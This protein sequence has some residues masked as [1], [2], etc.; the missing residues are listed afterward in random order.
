MRV[1][2]LN[3]LP[4]QLHEGFQLKAVSDHVNILM[5]TRSA[6][7]PVGE[8]EHILLTLSG[9][10][11]LLLG[12]R[13]I[14]VS[15]GV[16]VSV[17]ADGPVRAEPA[18]GSPLLILSQALSEVSHMTAVDIDAGA[19]GRAEV[20]AL[21][22]EP[23]PAPADAEEELETSAQPTAEIE[24]EA[25]AA[26][27]AERVADPSPRQAPP[28]MAE[29]APVEPHVPGEP[30]TVQ[31]APR[32]SSRRPI[33]QPAARQNASPAAV[34]PHVPDEPQTIQVA[35]R[36]TSRRLIAQ[37]AARQNASAAPQDV[38][39]ASSAANPPVPKVTAF[40]KNLPDPTRRVARRG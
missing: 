20:D 29:P 28:V 38:P 16:V 22:S 14:L 4:W 19:G 11:R 26:W 25:P 32:W 27:A 6:E 7:I 15:S 1:W 33:A 23:E 24:A 17:N 37:P 18:P 12:R 10:G 30:Q 35:P 36:W 13:V 5:V 31:N 40:P 21:T 2:D 34:E 8:E 39:E 9:Q 3:E